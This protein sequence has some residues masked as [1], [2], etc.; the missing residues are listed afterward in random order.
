MGKNCNKCMDGA[1]DYYCCLLMCGEL[2]VCRYC[3]WPRRRVVTQCPMEEKEKMDKI[4]EMGELKKHQNEQP[5]MTFELKFKPIVSEICTL[6]EINR[7]FSQKDSGDIIQVTLGNQFGVRYISHTSESV[8][9]QLVFDE[10]N[11]KP[12]FDEYRLVMI[13]FMY[14]GKPQNIAHIHFSLV[15]SSVP[16]CNAQV[17]KTLETGNGNK[18][19]YLTFK[20]HVEKI[21]ACREKNSL[22]EISHRRCSK[23]IQMNAKIFIKN[24]PKSVAPELVDIT[25]PDFEWIEELDDDTRI[26]IYCK[27]CD[28]GV[29]YLV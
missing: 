16:D 13:P 14:V 24:T 22:H 7:Y 25:D 12:N 17:N 3:N 27:L 20:E 18:K 11:T 6:E 4:L 28:L 29:P 19:H 21:R 10:S 23:G 9:V 8:K 1:P 2:E 5:D 15:E 26:K